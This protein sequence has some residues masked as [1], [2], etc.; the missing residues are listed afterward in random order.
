[1]SIV[2][3]DAS[4]LVKL[5]V[6]EPESSALVEFLH[7]RPERASSALTLVEVPRALRRAGL[8]ATE[9]QRAR[10]L[11][12]RVALIDVDRRSLAMAA[13]FDPPGLRTLDAIHLAA[14]L[15]LGEDLDGF[16]TYDRRLAEAARHIDLEVVAPA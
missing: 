3:L 11:L 6:A 13:A 16:V 9:R 5:V 10:R 8:G 15:A 1:V 12:T 7:A 2:Y 14:A 4:A